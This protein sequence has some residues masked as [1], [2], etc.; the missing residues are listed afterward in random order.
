MEGIEIMALTD[1][2]VRNAKLGPKPYKMG[3]SHGLFLLV[4]PTG[5]KLAV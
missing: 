1:V 2:T 3:D 4:Q 5:G